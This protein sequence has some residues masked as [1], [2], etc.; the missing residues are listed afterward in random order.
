[1]AT[2]AG[3]YRA[4]DLTPASAIFL[5]VFVEVNDQAC[6][7]ERQRHTNFN[8]QAFQSDDEHIRRSHPFHSFMT[9]DISGARY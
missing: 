4:R 7:V 8:A 9:Q 3:S 1:M 6:F 2:G 5:A